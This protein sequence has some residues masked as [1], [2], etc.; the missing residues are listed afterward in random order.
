MHVIEMLAAIDYGW[1]INPWKV[2]VLLVLLMIWARLL[3]W[4]DKDSEAAHLPRIPLNTVFLGGLVL[5]FVLFMMLAG[6]WVA[7]GVLLVILVA[8]VVTYLVLRNQKVGLNDLGRQF[9]SWIKGFGSKEKEVK[10]E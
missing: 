8:E 6:F 7:L 1:Y 5:A 4:T 10:A 2:V 9:N 3:T